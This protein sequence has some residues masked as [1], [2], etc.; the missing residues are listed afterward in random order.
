[1][2][3]YVCT[4]HGTADKDARGARRAHGDTRRTRRETEEK[5]ATRGVAAAAARP[6]KSGRGRTATS[7]PDKCATERD[8]GGGERET[9]RRTHQPADRSQSSHA[10]R[11]LTDGDRARRDDAIATAVDT[12]AR[13]HAR[14]SNEENAG[15]LKR[16]GTGINA[17]G[18]GGA[19]K[20]VSCLPRW[21]EEPFRRLNSARERFFF[22]RRIEAT[23]R[24]GGRTE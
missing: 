9:E 13:T 15:E 14:F 12:R 18:G 1:M 16:D 20:R 22:K 21:R 17:A 23:V 6:L 24:I 19:S 4:R 5:I 3:V 2:P 8:G 10:E 7:G 11:I